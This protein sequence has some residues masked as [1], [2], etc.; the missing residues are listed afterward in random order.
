MTSDPTI[1]TSPIEVVRT[2]LPRGG[3]R[4]VLF[5]FDGTLSLVRR[6]WQATMIPMMVDVLSET[7]TNETR[8]QLHAHVEEFVMRLNGKQTIY[9]MIQLADEVRARGKEPREPLEYKH[10]YHDLLWERVGQRVEGLRDGSI[11]PEEATVPGSH[12]LLDELRRRGLE[13]LLHRVPI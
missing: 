12:R 13:L 4:A 5:D 10:Q 3:Y 7:G 11:S 1:S 6:N 8:E 9:Q 2:N